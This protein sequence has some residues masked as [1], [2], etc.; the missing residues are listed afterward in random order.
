MDTSQLQCMIE[1]D[2]IL[3][4][5]IIGVFSADRLPSKLPQTPFGFIANTD[6]HS[7][8]GR[9]WCAFFSDSRGHFDFFDSYGRTSTQNSYHFRRW[10]K[11]NATTLR[12]N[13][14]Q[15]QSNNSK[16]C[17]LYCIL[18]LR[19]RLMEYTYQGFLNSFDDISLDTNDRY[20]ADLMTKTY[21]Q[22]LGIENNSNQI[23]TTFNHCI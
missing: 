11:Q 20:I 2:P 6:I 10:L 8:P 1:C 23:C 5:R 19:Q 7:K 17:G 3:N 13:H 21:S 15:I 14:K 18:F 12:S 9:H 22:C 4:D 16:V